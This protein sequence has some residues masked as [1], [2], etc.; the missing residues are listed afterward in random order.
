[1]GE[2]ESGLY[3]QDAGVGGREGYR[4]FEQRGQRRYWVRREQGGVDMRVGSRRNTES[5]KGF[6]DERFDEMFD[7]A[8]AQRS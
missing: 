6:D 3:C 8:S 7:E 5:G 1:M 2:G 4:E